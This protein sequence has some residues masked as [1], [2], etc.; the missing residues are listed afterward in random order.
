MVNQFE[1]VLNYYFFLAAL[2]CLFRSFLLGHI[3]WYI[4]D[5]L[6]D[7]ETVRQPLLDADEWR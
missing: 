5:K 6:G 3:A 1:L 7:E 2:C 4:N